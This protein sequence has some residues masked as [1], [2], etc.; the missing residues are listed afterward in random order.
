MIF[1]QF[2]I[3]VLEFSDFETNFYVKNVFFVLILTLKFASEGRDCNDDITNA[4]VNSCKYCE[5][6]V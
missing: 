2:I 4:A 3:Y 1:V 5:L 6:S